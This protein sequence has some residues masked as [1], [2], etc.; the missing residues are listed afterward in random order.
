MLVKDVIE[1]SEQKKFTV[2]SMFAGGGGSST[3]YRLA[4]G[5]VLLINEFVEEAVKSYKENYPDTTVI[6]DDIHNITGDDILNKIGLSLGELDILDGSPPCSAFS[7]A[8]KREKGWK[9]SLK[10]N[11]ASS[12]DENW[13]VISSG[14]VVESSGIKKYSDNK[15]V[16]GI[17]DLFLQFIRIANELK[18][19]VIIAE[20]VKGITIGEAKKKLGEFINAFSSIGYLTT[21]KVMNSAD[22]GVPQTRERTIFLCV[23]EDVAESLEISEL[24][25]AKLYPSPTV[26]KRI[27]IKEAIDHISNDPNEVEMLIDYCNNS[28]QKPIIEKLP[29]NP[30][31]IVK[32]SDKEHKGWNPKLSYFNMIRPCPDL[33]C[34]TLTQRGQQRSVSGVFHYNYNRKLTIL[35]LKAIMGLPEDYKLTGKWDQQAERI[36]RM[37][38]PKLIQAIAESVYE[39]VIKPYNNR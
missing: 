13:E 11:R 32:P 9:G 37:V 18:P 36:C 8:G 22:Y 35:E 28:F 26:K 34:P 21:Y 33:P 29:F 16:E 4:G 30:K 7:L 19:K 20:N 24:D 23:R 6:L 3:G 39:K 2:V 25:L 14:E 10:D 15:T 1:A 27:T 31:K 17:E 5:N 12:F 38:P